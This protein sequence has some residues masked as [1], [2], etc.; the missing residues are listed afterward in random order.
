MQIRRATRKDAYSLQQ[1]INKA[2]HRTT[3][4]PIGS[5]Y[6][7]SRDRLTLVAA[8]DEKIL[9]TASMH[10]LQKLDRKMGQIEDVVVHPKA[11][12]LGLGRRI[13]E[14]LLTETQSKECYKIVLN[15]AEK[16]IPF[17]E[18]MGFEVGE[19]QMVRRK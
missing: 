18:K 3:D 14:A 17:Y 19:L 7:E 9:A 1:L 2:F 4:T 13:V 11:Q 16:T 5:T 15:T 10:F 6:F 8:E 12:G